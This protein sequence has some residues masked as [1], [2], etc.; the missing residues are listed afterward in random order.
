MIPSLH[1]PACGVASLARAG[2]SLLAP[3][4]AAQRLRP[5]LQTVACSSQPAIHIQS[6]VA[7]I[8]GGIPAD[9]AHAA[10]DTARA[11]FSQG[12]PFVTHYYEGDTE[13]GGRTE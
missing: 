6:G 9:A 12:D 11:A 1:K 7:R 4:H 2:N 10:L 3:R 8:S 13:A 5:R